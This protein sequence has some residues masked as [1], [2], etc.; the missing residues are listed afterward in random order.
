MTRA[1]LIPVLALALALAACDRPAA[2][3]A[4]PARPAAPAA[5]AAMP[6]R[7]ALA[8]DGL[9]AI[10]AAT[11]SSQLLAFS[12]AKS[13]TLITMTRVEPAPGQESANAE[14]GAGPMSFVAWPDGLTLLFQDERFVGWTVDKPGLTT[15]DGI[16]VGST[17]AELLSARPGTTVEESTLGTEFTVGDMG[18]LLDGKGPDAKITTLWAG[19]TCMFR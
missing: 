11:G 8:P 12:R 3:P 1:R 2:T 14:C 15:M 9:N 18:G 17:R 16:G 6:L 7:L 19:V 5:P 4:A 10:V 13:Q